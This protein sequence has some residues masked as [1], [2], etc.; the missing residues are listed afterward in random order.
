MGDPVKTSAHLTGADISKTIQ[1][2]LN[3]KKNNLA[4]MDDPVKTAAHLSG[5]G[6]SKTSAAFMGDSEKTEAPAYRTEADISKRIQAK[7]NVKKKYWPSWVP[8]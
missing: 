6:I 1:T 8:A 4:F 3:V 7:L 2:K 5:A